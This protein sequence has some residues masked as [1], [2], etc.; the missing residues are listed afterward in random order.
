M[1]GLYIMLRVVLAVLLLVHGSVYLGFSIRSKQLGF[2]GWY[3][4]LIAALLSLVI[5][6]WAVELS[7]AVGTLGA[8]VISALNFLMLKNAMFGIFGIGCALILF[9]LSVFWYY[10]AFYGSKGLLHICG[11]MMKANAAICRFIKFCL[12]RKEAIR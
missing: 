11:Y 2:R 9:A 10:M 1:K 6:L 12:I 3:I 7:F 4:S 5:V 8:T